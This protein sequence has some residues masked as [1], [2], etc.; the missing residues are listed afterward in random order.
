MK[1]LILL[2]VFVLASSPLFSQWSNNP[3]VN[4]TV[5]NTGGF[6]QNVVTC[7]DGAG[8]IIMAWEDNSSGFYKIYSQKINVFGQTVWFS[9]GIGVCPVTG[10]QKA[11]SICSD[12]AGGAIVYWADYRTGGGNYDY[13]AQRIRT[14]GLLMWDAN[15]IKVNS[16]SS[17]VGYYQHKCISAEA[18]SSILCWGNSDLG[19]Y[20]LYTQKLDA[21]GVR[22][23]HP[24][25]V[26]LSFNWRNNFDL[27]YDGGKGAY[28]SYS[29]IDG[30]DFPYWNLWAQHVNA[31]GII[32]WP[33]GVLVCDD[34]NYQ[35]NPSMCEDQTG[36]FIVAWEDFR[37]FF[38]TPGFESMDIYTAHFNPSGVNLWTH[39]G[40]PV[41]T[42]THDQLSPVCISDL[43]SGAHIF[44]T[45][46]RFISGFSGE[47]IFGQNIDFNG[48]QRWNSNGKNCADRVDGFS[49]NVSQYGP[50]YAGCDALGGAIICWVGYYDDLLTQYG[51]L[52]QKI[53]YYGTKQWDSRGSF[54]STGA[55]KSGPSLIFDG[56]SGGCNV[57]WTDTRFGDKDILAQHV[58]TN[59]GLGNN[60]PKPVNSGS[61]DIIS[62]N[63]PNPF[64]PTTNIA[65]TLAKG[66]NISIRVFDMS[67]RELQ[68]LVDGLV[69]AGDHSVTW[70]A[71]NYASGTYFYKFTNGNNVEVKKMFL[72]K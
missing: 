59:S 25:D 9:G 3:A 20:G 17:A 37:S 6:Q 12:A 45:D 4:N 50:K 57:A 36:G 54:V 60:K 23:W 19:F 22:T 26:Y 53:D 71:S 13:Y 61:K 48:V 24:N 5:T 34:F 58:K 30:A 33:G 64:N 1:K 16:V 46:F 39:N 65:F 21:F 40:T 68:V 38:Y 55:G 66:A 14:D 41:C 62:Q 67:G 29:E 56:G 8:G 42:E 63:Y 10:D 70:N 7:P 72:V 2:F 11:P 15:G 31:L 49:T 52:S 43:H 47:N 28:Y 27:C 32:Q 69:T 44:W 18:G 35:R 51:I